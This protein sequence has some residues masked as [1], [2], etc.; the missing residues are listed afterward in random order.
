MYPYR[1]I[2]Y[3]G[4]HSYG[5]STIPDNPNTLTRKSSGKND[6]SRYP[7]HGPVTWN[8]ARTRPR[9]TLRLC[10]RLR[11]RNSANVT[12]T[13]RTPTL[14]QEPAYCS[15]RHKTL[16]LSLAYSVPCW[17]PF[18]TGLDSLFLTWFDSPFPTGFDSVISW[19]DST[20]IYCTYFWFKS[21]HSIIIPFK[22][23]GF[24]HWTGRVSLK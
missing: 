4:R 13:A 20:N 17:P 10:T 11:Y 16:A 7:L 15:V 18:L 14:C 6:A 23:Q 21:H 19:F 9:S 22:L 1:G 12:I 5:I 2:G 24:P 8:P 3:T